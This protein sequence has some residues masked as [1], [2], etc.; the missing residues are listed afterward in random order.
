MVSMTGVVLGWVA[1]SRFSFLWKYGGYVLLERRKPHAISVTL[2][3]W[4]YAGFSLTRRLAIL[5]LRPRN[6]VPVLH[7]APAAVLECVGNFELSHLPVDD[8]PVFSFFLE[9]TSFYQYTIKDFCGDELLVA[10]MNRAKVAIPVL[11]DEICN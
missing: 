7:R 2:I 3:E 6:A 4:F 1:R 10:L 8:G 11:V 9:E 5:H